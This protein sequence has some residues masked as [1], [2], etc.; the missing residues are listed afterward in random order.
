MS[1]K[2]DSVNSLSNIPGIALG[3]SAKK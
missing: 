2:S 1:R 3:V